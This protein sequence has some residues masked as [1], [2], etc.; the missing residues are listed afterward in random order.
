M[1]H[2]LAFV[3]I[4]KRY[5]QQARKVMNALW[6]LDGLMLTKMLVVV[7]SDVNVHDEQLVWQTIGANVHPGRDVLFCEGPTHMDDHAAPV[8]GMGHKMG[9]DATR[10][11]PEEGHPRPWPPPLAMNADIIDLVTQRWNEYG[12]K[13]S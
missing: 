4:E 3:S 11:L 13:K 5:P 12:I 6:G 10:K 8:R 7:D 1:L 2:S 9:I